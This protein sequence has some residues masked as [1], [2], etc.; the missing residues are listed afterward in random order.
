MTSSQSHPCIRI[1]FASDPVPFVPGGSKRNLQ[2]TYHQVLVAESTVAES[3]AIK[4]ISIG[5]LLV[6]SPTAFAR[7][8]DR[9]SQSVLTYHQVLV[10]QVLARK[11]PVSAASRVIN[12]SLPPVGVFV[13][14]RRSSTSLE[15]PGCLHTSLSFLGQDQRLKAMPG[16]EL[17]QR[18][19]VEWPSGQGGD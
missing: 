12:I 15:Q 10:H 7:V 18:M 11:E 5:D 17:H 13:L 2:A 16:N 1:G 9:P 14:P 6:G 4:T 8:R 19:R 3:T